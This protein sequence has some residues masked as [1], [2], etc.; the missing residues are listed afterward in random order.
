MVALEWT[1]NSTLVVV[2]QW[3]SFFWKIGNHIAFQKDSIIPPPPPE[4]HYTAGHSVFN[5][6][7]RYLEQRADLSDKNSP[8]INDSVVC[9][10]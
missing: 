9:Q 4:F 6:V 5:S 10:I 1:D 8:K 7:T 2:I 3:P